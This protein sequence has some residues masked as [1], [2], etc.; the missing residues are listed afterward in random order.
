MLFYN[1][2]Y[3]KSEQRTSTLN[4]AQGDQ[5]LLNIWMVLFNFAPIPNYTSWTN[6]SVVIN[7]ISNI[8]FSSHPVDENKKVYTVI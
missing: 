8:H 2:N 3:C 4:L 6:I 7:W 5:H 1:I